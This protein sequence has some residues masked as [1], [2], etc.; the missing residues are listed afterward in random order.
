MHLDLKG[1]IEI[2]EVKTCE[3][4]LEECETQMSNWK[5]ENR[6]NIY[7]SSNNGIIFQ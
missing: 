6:I 2:T 4:K 5:N 3:E 7:L 1:G